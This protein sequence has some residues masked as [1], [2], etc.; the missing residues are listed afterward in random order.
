[1]SPIP[2]WCRHEQ[3]GCKQIDAVQSPCCMV[4]SVPEPDLSDLAQRLICARHNVSPRRLAAPGPSI[5]Q[6]LCLLRAAAAAP[7]H[8]R[9]T[10]WRFVIVPNDKRASLAAAFASALADNAPDATQDQISAAQEK[11]YRAPFMMVAIA[12]LQSQKAS[13]IPEFERYVSLGSAIQNVLLMAHAMGYGAGLT[14]GKSLHSTYVRKLFHLTEDEQ[15]VCSV[16]IG[17][18]VKQKAPHSRPHPR[19]F[20]STL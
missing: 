5:A 9:L 2:D 11:A 20:V 18:I 14:S 16:N 10:P 1:M 7:D 15:P 4:S 19:E 6:I 12:R 13:D 8:D 17:T 3:A